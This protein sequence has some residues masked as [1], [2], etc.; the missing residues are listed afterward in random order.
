SRASV[1]A[2][3][4][5]TQPTPSLRTRRRHRRSRPGAASSPAPS[6]AAT[7]PSTPTSS[8]PEASTPSHS[9]PTSATTPLA[10]VTHVWLVEL[11]GSTFAEALAAPAMAAYIDTQ[12][13][14]AGELL[15]GWSGLAGSALANEAALLAD[16]PPQLVQTV[17]QPPCPE[18]A[19]A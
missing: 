4:A 6:S 14:G 12:A 8:S 16:T 10:P 3:T 17:V 13:I 7:T 18:G 19:A 5:A 2:G 15:S 11:A 9:T 1:A